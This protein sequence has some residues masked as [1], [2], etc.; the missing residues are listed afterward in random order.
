VPELATL[1]RVGK[2]AW[3]G[4]IPFVEGDGPCLA[5]GCWPTPGLLRRNLLPMNIPR[6]PLFKVAHAVV[7]FEIV[8]SIATYGVLRRRLSFA[9]KAGAAVH[10]WLG[11]L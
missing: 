3:S 8:R 1:P 4:A 6:Q 2:G 11:W 5:C 7:Y 10:A 9:C